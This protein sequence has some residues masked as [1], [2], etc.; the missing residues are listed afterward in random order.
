MN[1]DYK[2]NPVINIFAPARSGG[3]YLCELL[4]NFI[5]LNSQKIIFNMRNR[6]ITS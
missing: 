2:L 4:D 3:T 6:I 5:N 1:E